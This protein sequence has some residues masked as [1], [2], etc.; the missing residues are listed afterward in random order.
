M[1]SNR[2]ERF[3]SSIDR[4]KFYFWIATILV[5][6][7]MILALVVLTHETLTA[8]RQ[9]EFR[10]ISYGNY[11]PRARFPKLDSLPIKEVH[12]T[13]LISFLNQKRKY[14]FREL[15]YMDVLREKYGKF[16]LDVIGVV[17]VAEPG[18]LE[19]YSKRLN[20]KYP[21]VNDSS[22]SLFSYVGLTPSGD[23]ELL[24]DANDT[25]RL[26]VP[27]GFN[28]NAIR[29]VL[30]SSFLDR[31]IISFKQN[32]FDSQVRVSDNIGLIDIVEFDSLARPR[33]KKLIDVISGHPTLVTFVDPF[34]SFCREESLRV[35]TLNAIGASK[36]IRLGMVLLHKTSVDINQVENFLEE[37]NF[38]GKSCFTYDR[39]FNLNEYYPVTLHKKNV[40][41]VLVDGRGIVEFVE[42]THS[43]ERSLYEN[44]S[45]LVSSQ[46]N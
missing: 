26:V 18:I 16:G 12:H 37:L 15:A 39:V 45:V 9:T 40:I 43:D 38:T 3:L 23:G 13:L 33:I 7:V 34:C 6:D 31:N 30:E 4:K 27:G 1:I 46:M 28:E 25:V 11:F 44:I 2:I 41:S 42:S 10:G 5:V 22:G 8:P 36:K 17:S 24:I 29:Q 20:I 19:E 21:L 32:D 14:F 35:A